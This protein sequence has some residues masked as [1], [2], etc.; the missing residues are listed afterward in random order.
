MTTNVRRMVPKRNCLVRNI[1]GFDKSTNNSSLILSQSTVDTV[2]FITRFFWRRNFS[3][4]HFE[5]GNVI[6][7]YLY[8]EIFAAQSKRRAL[9]AFKKLSPRH[10]EKSIIHQST[11]LLAQCIATYLQ[12]KTQDYG[13]CYLRAA[14]ESNKVRVGNSV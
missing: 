8:T 7:N 11:I 6:I 13:L 4:W 1:F 12:W 5:V 9:V 14:L 3:G 10:Q 2:A